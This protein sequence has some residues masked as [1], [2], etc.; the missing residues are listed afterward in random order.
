MS[1]LNSFS[2][3]T[4]TGTAIP[5]ILTILAVAQS[6]HD[7]AMSHT[8]GQ[9]GRN[10][11]RNR[12]FNA[13]SVP[14]RS[15]GPFDGSD[16]SCRLTYPELGSLRCLTYHEFYSDEF[17]GQ[18]LFLQLTTR[19]GDLQQ[20]RPLRATTQVRHV[21][22]VQEVNATSIEPLRPFRSFARVRWPGR[23]REK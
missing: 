9:I 5:L 7:S 22:S 2:S 11:G 4:A 1:L 3:R 19:R 8:V 14:N 13:A 15:E 10:S 12:R 23:F 20:L 21:R 16:S 17:L 6:R 18:R